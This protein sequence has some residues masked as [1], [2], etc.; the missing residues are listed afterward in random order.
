MLFFI[1][2]AALTSP[3]S[4]A[5]RAAGWLQM[6]KG[7][8]EISDTDSEANDSGQHVG[9]SFTHR[10]AMRNGNSRFLPTPFKEVLSNLCAL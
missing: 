7:V 6:K 9:L 8:P 2:I 4:F 1:T 3:I 5:G 10:R